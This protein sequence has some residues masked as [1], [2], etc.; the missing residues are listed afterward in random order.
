MTVHLIVARVYM[1]ITYTLLAGLVASVFFKFSNGYLT[2][3]LF[4]CAPL[5]GIVVISNIK[6]GYIP[7]Y[8]KKE[9]KILR[10]PFESSGRKLYV[11][12]ED[13]ARYTLDPLLLPKKCNEDE[14]HN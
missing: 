5:S 9:D 2:L 13:G 11:F 3:A 6:R 14:E 8:W 12:D 10:I 1:A 7:L 4:C